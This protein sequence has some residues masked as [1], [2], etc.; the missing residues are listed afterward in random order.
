MNIKYNQNPAL[1]KLSLANKIYPIYEE[2]KR[3]ISSQS[4]PKFEI[5]LF[6]N[7]KTRRTESA[8]MTFIKGKYILNIEQ[9]TFLIT[10][11]TINT[12]LYHEF[13]HIWDDV[14]FL[15]DLKYIE[16][17]KFLHPYTEYHATQIE[18]MCACGF[19]KMDDNKALDK[20]IIVYEGNSPKPITEYIKFIQEDYLA[21]IKDKMRNNCPPGAAVKI[22]L[23]S[24]YL[25][26]KIDFFKHFCEFNIDEFIDINIAEKICGEHFIQSIQLIQSD[27]CKDIQYFKDLYNTTLKV[28]GDI[29][30]NYNRILQLLAQV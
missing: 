17:K 10:T 14:T 26:S 20:D 18:M 25:Q 13:T 3:F 5:L 30:N 8:S 23:H 9:H 16:R 21:T 22:W 11:Q 2:Y 4:L 24:I 27:T 12:L 15:Q 7:L 19:N 1:I 6:N 29:H 28:G